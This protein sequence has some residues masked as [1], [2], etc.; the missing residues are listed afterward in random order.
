MVPVVC[1]STRLGE[2]QRERCEGAGLVG[3]RAD[4]L[5]GLCHSAGIPVVHG[6]ARRRVVGSRS[7]AVG[8]LVA[9]CSLLPVSV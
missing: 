8:E 9:P 7:W 3:G 1:R 2:T 6:P 4:G 5:S